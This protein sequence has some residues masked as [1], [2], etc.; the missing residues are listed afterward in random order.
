MT[1]IIKKY[2]ISDYIYRF[3]YLIAIII[4]AVCVFF[5]FSGSS[6]GMWEDY[7]GI[8]TESGTGNLLGGSRAIR[9]DEWAVNTPMA[10]SQYYNQTGAFPYY[11]DT[12]R[13]TETDAFIVYGQPVAGWQMIFRLFQIGYLLFLPAKGLSFFWCGRLI[14]LIMVSFE[15][16]MYLFGK[17]KSYA[18]I[19]S[20]LLSFSP[21][22]SWWFAINGLVEMLVF[23]Q[24]A[25]LLIILYLRTQ[26]YWKRIL[27]MLGLVVCAG[28]YILVFYPSWQI[29]LAYVFLFLLIGILIREFKKENW[30]WKK[31][32]P[33]LLS[34]IFI[35]G[36]SV[37]SI[38][39]Q[40]LDTIRAVMGT[41]YPG[42]RSYNGDGAFENLTNWATNILFPYIDAGFGDTNVCE[43][44]GIVSFFPLGIIIS[45]WVLFKE[46]K[47]DPLLISGLVGTVFLT[48]YCV[49]PW[50]TFFAKATL[51]SFCQ[52]SRAALGVGVL[53]LFILLYALYI[54]ESPIKLKI[55]IVIS[56]GLT[57]LLTSYSYV[58][59]P[60]LFQP[61]RLVIIL[62]I[63]FIGLFACFTV[64]YKKGEKIFIAVC[65]TLAV[66]GGV[67]V[68]P[69][70][71]GTDVIYKNPL[72]QEIA[73]VVEEDGQGLWIVENMDFPYINIP[74][75]VGAP[76]I[77][78][79]NTYPDLERWELLDETGENEKKYNRYAHISIR[80]C[81]AEDV[82]FENPA[83]D[84]LHV[85]LPVDQLKTLNVAHILTN[86]DLTI[87]N[88]ENIQF[89]L[90][91]QIENYRIY[92][93]NYIEV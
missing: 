27:Y 20:A 84:Q 86:Q 88:S 63:T 70:H 67:T 5:E 44:A 39:L 87:Y 54:L 66:V 9:T 30:K 45:L 35:L 90:V 74:I 92:N 57:A 76:T 11:S 89:E 17:K 10:F 6:I 72:I 37:G 46:K 33:I 18:I 1:G 49:L 73:A 77:N 82:S 8:E 62:V 64:M 85:A 32:L 21:V 59:N 19:Y 83:P 60:D 52:P 40:S 23:G 28:S 68:N 93:V 69:L 3:R 81:E 61:G 41:A 12:M 16:G 34:F 29:P 58:K 71:Q 36:V 38:L 42:A 79:T 43:E 26:K 15:M 53:S 24:A 78:C 50:P 22:V 31:D 65:L 91:N 13:G 14:A 7:I 48:A 25:L 75:M 51:L 4:F 2:K 80:L 56:I 47:R 55:G